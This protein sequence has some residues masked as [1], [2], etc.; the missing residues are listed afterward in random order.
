MPP[1][2]AAAKCGGVQRIVMAGGCL[3]I[4]FYLNETL[5]RGAY[6]TTSD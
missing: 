3:D 1:A 6:V 4:G 5:E 2:K